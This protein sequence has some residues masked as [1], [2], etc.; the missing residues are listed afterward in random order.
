MYRNAVELL[1]QGDHNGARPPL[2]YKAVIGI[3]SELRI[4]AFA[5]DAASGQRSDKGKAEYQS[6]H[7]IT[8][9]RL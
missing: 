8:I 6:L 9:I 2:A 5:S 3:D 4:F 1:K 7:G